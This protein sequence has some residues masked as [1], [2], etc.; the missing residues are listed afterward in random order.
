MLR[1]CPHPKSKSKPKNYP[2]G[3]Y[4]ALSTQDIEGKT[5]L[6]YSVELALLHPEETATLRNLL[7]LGADRTVHDKSGESPLSIVKNSPVDSRTRAKIK[8]GY[9]ARKSYCSCCMLKM[10]LAR[11][12]KSWATPL[13]YLFLLLF[14]H[15]LLFFYFDPIYGGK[16]VLPLNLAFCFL[17]LLLFLI[18]SCKNA[19]TLQQL[20]PSLF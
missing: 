15:F 16:V 20:D 10:P 19:G 1:F 7:I 18:V 13:F 4:C 11:I 5:P 14:T 6:H 3:R 2:L 12:S 9:L 8:Q 17:S